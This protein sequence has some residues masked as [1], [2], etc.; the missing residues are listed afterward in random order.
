[1]AGFIRHKGKV[2]FRSQT[3][4]AVYFKVGHFSSSNSLIWLI[5]LSAA[6]GRIFHL[7]VSSCLQLQRSNCTLAEGVMEKC[8]SI[9][10][11]IDE[12]INS[13]AFVFCDTSKL[14]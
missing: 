1:M 9:R 8:S 4:A 2:F 13:G 12:D 6:I 5:N 7:R 14:V 3:L 10:Q 11:V